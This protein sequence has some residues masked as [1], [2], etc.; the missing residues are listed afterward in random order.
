MWAKLSHV[1]KS[2]QAHDESEANFPGEVMAGVLEQHPN[3]SIFQQSSEQP[4]PPPSPSKSGRMA[5]F[6]RNTKGYDESQRAPSP[7]KLIPKK[8]KT[9]LG[10][11]GNG[12]KLSRNPN[13]FLTRN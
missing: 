3:L 5:M 2:K 1:L 10:I 7:L 8:V 12:A 9:T 11:Q 6:K 4:S 13:T